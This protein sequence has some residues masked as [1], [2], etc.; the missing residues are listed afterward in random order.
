MQMSAWK[1]GNKNQQCWTCGAVFGPLQFTKR[2]IWSTNGFTPE[3]RLQQFIMFALVWFPLFEIQLSSPKAIEMHWSP[4]DSSRPEWRATEHAGSAGLPPQLLSG[5]IMLSK[6]QIKS[7]ISDMFSAVKYGG[8]WLFHCRCGGGDLSENHGG[9][10]Y[11][12]KVL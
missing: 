2:L 12:L 5:N 10:L 11:L 4:N 3:I 7:N 6:W 9:V 1:H 8:F